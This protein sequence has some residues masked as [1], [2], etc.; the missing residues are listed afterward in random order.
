MS[1]ATLLD[2]GQGSTMDPESDDVLVLFVFS[3]SISYSTW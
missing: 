1:Y 3:S 2:E